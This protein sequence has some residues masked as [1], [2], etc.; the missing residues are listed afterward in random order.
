MAEA[1]RV[2]PVQTLTGM[3]TRTFISIMAVSLGVVAMSAASAYRAHL[4]STAP[5]YTPADTVYKVKTVY[6]NRPEPASIT[7]AGTIKVPV[8]MFLDN[9]DTTVIERTETI[10]DTMY[11]ALD[12][13]VKYFSELDGRLRIWVSGYQ[14]ELECYELDEVEK[15]ALPGKKLNRLSFEA[16]V[17]A[18]PSA[19]FPLTVEYSRTVGR[20][21]I[22]ARGGYEPLSRS[23]IV[24]TGAR[25][26]L[27][28]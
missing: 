21:D 2:F 20:F 25:Y 8:L 17:G 11:V 13:T 5:D 24:E 16:G 28:F 19:A 15:T 23:G 26:S 10:H 1:Y 18:I 22:F 4:K 9:G 12:R 6:R 7:A 14:P 27:D 3:D